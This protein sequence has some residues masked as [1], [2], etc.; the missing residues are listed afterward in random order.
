MRSARSLL[1]MCSPLPDTYGPRRVAPFGRLRL[2]GCSLVG[3]ATRR[4]IMS[5]GARSSPEHPDKY[6][7]IDLH[8]RRSVIVRMDGSG[9]QLG[10]ARIDNSVANLLGAVEK[11]GPDAE[12]VLEACYGWVRHEAPCDRVRCETSSAGCRSS[13]LKLEAA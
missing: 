3:E 9:K 8:H 7:G 13:P 5:P 12:V 10:V 4:S 1:M 11:A 2:S 6:V